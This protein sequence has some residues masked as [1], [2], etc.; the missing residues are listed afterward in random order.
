[1]ARTRRAEACECD[2]T[3]PWM[4]PASRFLSALNTLWKDD[5]HLVSVPDVCVPAAAGGGLFAVAFLAAADEFADFGARLRGALAWPPCTS[6]FRRLRSLIRSSVACWTCWASSVASA[7][8][9]G[10]SWTAGNR[11]G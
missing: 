5:Y 11:E 8:G 9:G 10:I 4:F 2:E 1:P 3:L 6:P 7:R